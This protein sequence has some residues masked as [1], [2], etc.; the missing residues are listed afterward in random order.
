MSPGCSQPTT[1]CCCPTAPL[2]E[3]HCR[4]LHKN[5]EDPSEV[6]GGFLSDLNPVS[7]SSDVLQPSCPQRWH[8]EGLKVLTVLLPPLRTPYVWWTMPWL[9]ALSSGH[10]PLISSS[11]SAW[12]TS[13]W[14]LT[15][16]TAR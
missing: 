9:T 6:P 5:P 15:A 2:A 14:I 8:A 4:F 7:A 16:L 13:Q 3:S 1:G 10:G 11:L 12:A